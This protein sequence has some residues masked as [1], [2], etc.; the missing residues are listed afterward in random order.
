MAVALHVLFIGALEWGLGVGTRSTQPKPRMPE[1]DGMEGSAMQWIEF[2]GR[3]ESGEAA[4]DAPEIVPVIRPITVGA[5]PPEVVIEYAGTGPEQSADSSEESERSQLYG[6]Y[7][8]QIDARIERAW[9][10]PRTPIGRS[11]SCTAG[12]EQDEAGN[13]KEIML[14]RC[15]GDA[16]WQQ[17]LVRG[18]Q[19][20]SPLPAPPDPKVF[21]RHITLS[22]RAETYSD[23]SDPYLY[24]PEGI[25]SGLQDRGR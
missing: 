13:I 4:R 18:I 23:R 9:L 22:F 20:A 5:L 15:N 1:G 24:E 25:I 16:R 3:G 11:F 8:G 12:I 2:D 19:A 6:Q 10:R 17:S 14:V 7:L 21:R